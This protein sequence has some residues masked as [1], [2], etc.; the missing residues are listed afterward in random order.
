VD[1]GLIRAAYDAHNAAGRDFPT[2]LARDYLLP[3]VEFVEAAGV[4]GATTHRGRDAV[5]ALFSDRFEAGAMSIE[6]L[7]VTAIDDS[8][9]LAA[10]RVRIRGS[11]SGAEA[12]MPLWNLVTLHG[13]RIARVEEFTEEED[14][15]AA[16]RR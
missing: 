1:V 13:S 10:F 8:R 12:A 3:D 7:E 11:G 4:P 14:A 5:T 6:D 16:A 2:V 15:L 9:A